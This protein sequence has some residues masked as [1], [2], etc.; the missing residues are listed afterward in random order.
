MENKSITEPYQYD[1]LWHYDVQKNIVYRN[2]LVLAPTPETLNQIKKQEL[3]KE[4]LQALL[5][6]DEKDEKIVGTLWAFLT[7]YTNYLT[8]KDKEQLIIK[9]KQT[10]SSDY[11]SEHNSLYLNYL[12]TN[13]SQNN[14][15]FF[16]EILEQYYEF[17]KP[18]I[19]SMATIQ[20][21]NTHKL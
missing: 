21:I 19:Q 5:K 6:I 16:D 2:G 17:N 7:E 1:G 18:D 10:S 11:I 20:D 4:K 13:L 8:N 15:E 14:M 3:A 12:Q 9:L